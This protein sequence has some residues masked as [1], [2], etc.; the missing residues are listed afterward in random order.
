[1]MSAHNDVQLC[2]GRQGGE[3]C[4]ALKLSSRFVLKTGLHLACAAMLALCVVACNSENDSDLWGDAM[5]PTQMQNADQG[6]G[7][8]G[9]LFATTQ[10]DS[11][12]PFVDNS[13][14]PFVQGAWWS[15][16]AY[17]GG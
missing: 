10:G 6:P 11:D 4:F 2:Q 17:N 16:P 15:N 9:N 12:D 3:G 1:M 8:G 13:S 5:S 7:P 14:Y